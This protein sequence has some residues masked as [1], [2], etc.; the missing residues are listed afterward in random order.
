MAR[1]MLEAEP[2]TSAVSPRKAPWVSC[3]ALAPLTLLRGRASGRVRAHDREVSNPIGPLANPGSKQGSNRLG[4]W[5]RQAEQHNSRPCRQSGTPSELAKVLVESQQ[6]AFLTHSPGEN[7]TSIVNSRSIRTNPRNIMSGFSKRGNSRARKILVGEK[8]H[9][10][11]RSGILFRPQ[12]IARV[13]EAGRDI[14]MRE[15]GVVAQDVG[16]GPTVCHETDDEVDRQARPSITGFPAS[17][18]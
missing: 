10:A 16:L 15:A 1:P 4:V 13:C 7:S 18:V 11:S 9:M 5:H 14:L 3:R 6:N 17:M 12:H 8:A 2:V